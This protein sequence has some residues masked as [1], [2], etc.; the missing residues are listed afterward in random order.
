MKKI[1]LIFV[2]IIALAL[3]SGCVSQDDT[4]EIF[5][6]VSSTEDQEDPSEEPG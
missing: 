4:D 6:Q 2:L 3:T 5:E 1:R